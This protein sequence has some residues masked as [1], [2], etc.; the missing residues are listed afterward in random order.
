MSCDDF[1]HDVS[2]C[3]GCDLCLAADPA[4]D[5]VCDAQRDAWVADMEAAAAAQRLPWELG[6]EPAND[7]LDAGEAA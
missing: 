3:C 5:D 2:C 1:H 6:F 4:Y 7:A